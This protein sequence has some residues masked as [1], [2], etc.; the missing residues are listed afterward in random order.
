ML[1]HRHL[2]RHLLLSHRIAPAIAAMAIVVICSYAVAANQEHIA[3][4]GG[5]VV[6]TVVLLNALGYA[7][8]WWL[9]RLYGFDA[10]YQ[11]TLAI[12]IG[13]QNAGLGVVLAL[14]H[15][16]AETALPGALFAVWCI[17]TA[18]GASSWLRRRQ[19]QLA[20]DSV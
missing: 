7:A 11:L 15:F 8:G 6:T 1:L 3:A 9:A 4:V 19:P 14:K 18:A 17:L 2:G 20:E 10:R 5:W 13:M 12:E 16:S